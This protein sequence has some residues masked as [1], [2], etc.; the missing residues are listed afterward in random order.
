MIDSVCGFVVQA[1]LILTITLSGLGSLDLSP[2][3]SAP[4]FDGKV[5]MVALVLLGL[6]VIVAVAVP[7]IRA[8][9]RGRVA[10]LAVALRALRSPSKVALIF[11]GNLAAQI[12]LAAILGLC[13]DAFGQHATLADLI[14][15][16]TFVSLFAGFM[17]VPGGIG[18]AEAGYTAGLAALGIP[19]TAA[20]S[21]TLAFRIVTFYLPPIWG[22]PALRWLRAHSYL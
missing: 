6:A 1:L 4:S 16:N 17:P 3:G 8:V 15:V 14:L 13:L 10:D 20:L 12:L 22:A 11:L 7:R 21:T 18:V 9:V 19:H 5:L 2:Q